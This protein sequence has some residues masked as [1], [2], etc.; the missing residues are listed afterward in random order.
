MYAFCKISN[1]FICVRVT[2]ARRF[3][4]LINACNNKNKIVFIML[5]KPF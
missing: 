4:N 2:D 1:C 3:A 5:L